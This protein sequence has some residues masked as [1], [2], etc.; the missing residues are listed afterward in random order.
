M[1]THHNYVFNSDFMIYFLFTMLFKLVTSSMSKLADAFHQLSVR[2]ETP[3]FLK[4]LAIQE[5]TWRNNFECRGGRGWVLYLT[6][7]WLAVILLISK[8]KA[9]FCR[10]VLTCLQL[11]VAMIFATSYVSPHTKYSQTPIT[12][13]SSKKLIFLVTEQEKIWNISKPTKHKMA[14]KDATGLPQT[15]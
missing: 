11:A 8:K 2:I 12:L 5:K 15:H 3:S 10:S 6:D 7:V 14:N 9:I 1:K 4:L 13:S